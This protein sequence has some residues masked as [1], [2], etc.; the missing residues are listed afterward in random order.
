MAKP[1]LKRKG[2]GGIAGGVKVAVA[3]GAVVAR[4]AVVMLLP[5]AKV[6]EGVGD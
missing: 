5:D 3:L 2:E 4:L 1:A 6:G